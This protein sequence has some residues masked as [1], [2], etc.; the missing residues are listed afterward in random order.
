R[1][2]YEALRYYRSN[3][4]ISE[5]F[6]IGGDGDIFEGVGWRKAGNHT[7]G[8]N[9]NSLGIAFI[10]NFEHEGPG[11]LMMIALGK[12]LTCAVQKG[13]LTADYKLLGQK[14][15]SGTYTKSPGRKL[16]DIIKRLPNW[17]ASP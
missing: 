1:I 3:L 17:T 7:H 8:Y 5:R 9:S 16:Y 13:E 10:G 11:D 2:D 15:V 4:F 14:Q 6:L 12:L